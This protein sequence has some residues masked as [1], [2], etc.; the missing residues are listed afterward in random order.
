MTR[1]KICGI[2]DPASARVA[3]DAGA[4]AIGLLFAPS[5]RRVTPARAQEIAAS[6]PPFVSRVGVFVDET[7]ERIAELIASC[8]LDA[9]QL[10]GAEPP[11]FCQGFRVPVIKALRVQNASS[12]DRMG[13]YRVG[14]FLLDT[15]DASALGGSG[16]TFDWSLAVGAA[17]THRVIL[18]GGLT[19]E[20]VTDALTQVRPYGVDVSS[21]VETD[22]RKDHAKI[23]AF[24]R[25]VREWDMHQTVSVTIPGSSGLL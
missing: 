3:A 8:G 12:L 4:D 6:L 21:G 19:P 9:V 24:I 10:H 23:R 17:Q 5:R 16:R 2:S 11:Q 14:A 25:R 18:S 20:T 22:G 1:V 13:D 15:Y 7:H